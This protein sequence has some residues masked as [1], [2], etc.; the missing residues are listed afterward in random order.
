MRDYL[1]ILKPE[2]GD[3]VQYGVLGM[4]WG[5]RR[6]DAQI[7]KDTAE[8]KA[9]GEKVTPTKKVEVS[10]TTTTHHESASETSAQRYSRLQS[11]A[12]QGKAHEMSEADLKFF[13]SRTEALS[14]IN[15]MNQKNPSWLGETSKKVLQQA[16]QNTMQQI[17]DGVAKKY[18]SQP[19][20]DQINNVEKKK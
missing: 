9:S 5:R 16:A 14:K 2:A 13:N 17:A 20:L 8:R 11:Q 4:K 1:A 10:S 15:K 19:I 6:T 18:V 3:A 7:A 12:K